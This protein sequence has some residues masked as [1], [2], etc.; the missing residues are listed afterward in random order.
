MLSVLIPVHN[1]DIRNLLRQIAHQCSQLHIS[2]EIICLDDASDKS[3]EPCFQ[4]IRKELK[5]Q[6]SSTLKNI[7]RSA[8]RNSLARQASFENLLFLDCD[9]SIPNEHFIQ[10]YIRLI[11]QEDYQVV[12]GACVY[13]KEKPR[14]TKKILHWIY[15]TK[16]ENPDLKHRLKYPY[17]TFHTV[18]FLAKRSLLL[19]YPFDE[20]ITKY[21]YE[22]SLWA[23]TLKLQ[24]IPIKHIENPVQHNGIYSNT[25]FLR[26]T[27]QSVR[28]LIYLDLT[29]KT[30]DTQLFKMINR[31]Q[32]IGLDTLFFKIYRKT[33]KFIVKNLMSKNPS[34][35]FL[36]IYKMGLFL[37]FKRKIKSIKPEILI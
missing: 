9:V 18:N 10:N 22:D 3:F 24:A 6:W 5:I 4:E 7:G 30:I 12:Y 15:G 17:E 34:M 1:Y 13:C 35:T 23:H 27:A 28:N 31:I 25:I 36:S 16:N 20:T 32:S 37:R 8:A 2:Y 11:K 33:E 26:K 29:K 21:G 14:D 19:K